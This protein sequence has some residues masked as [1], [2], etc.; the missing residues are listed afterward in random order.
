MQN[1]AYSQR[2]G[3]HTW[4]YGYFFMSHARTPMQRGLHIFARTLVVRDLTCDVAPGSVPCLDL[5]WEVENP[6]YSVSQE[7]LLAWGSFGRC[8]WSLFYSFKILF[9][10]AYLEREAKG[11]REMLILALGSLRYYI[12]ARSSQYR[13][14]SGWQLE[15]SKEAGI[16]II[17]CLQLLENYTFSTWLK[18]GTQN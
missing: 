1:L 18:L 15:M 12:K 16:K 7:T 3:Q 14:D 11:I 4:W 13:T 6:A 17:I 10:N 5:A 9:F 2:L 8:C